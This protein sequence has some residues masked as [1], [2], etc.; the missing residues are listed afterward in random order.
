MLES[1]R[2]V[3]LPFVLILIISLPTIFLDKT[4]SF[5][6]INGLNSPM[7]DLFFKNVTL[8]GEGFLIICCFILALFRPTKW[9]L[10]LV[11]GVAIHI[12]LIQINKQILFNHVMRPMG[13]F[14]DDG[15]GALVHLVEGIVIRCEVSFPSGHT[16]GATFGAVFLAAILGRKWI[17]WALAIIAM[18]VGISRVYLAQHFVIDVYFGYFFGLISF[19]LAA[20]IFRSWIP[21]AAWP[22]QYISQIFPSIIRR[23]FKG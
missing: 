15:I 3:L 9:F 10:V 19:I 4:D 22:D 2:S 5:L 17:A 20:L 6:F 23:R 8:L 14:N 13:T 1:N 7:T 18:L 12:A 11:L 21:K 16:T